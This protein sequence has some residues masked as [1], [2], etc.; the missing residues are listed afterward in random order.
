MNT[1]PPGR[2]GRLRPAKFLG[3]SITFP[4]LSLKAAVY[5]VCLG[6]L[7][8]TLGI[9]AYLLSAMHSEELIVLQ[10][11]ARTRALLA[12]SFVDDQM[13]ALLRTLKALPAEDVTQNTESRIRA[14]LDRKGIVL[15]TRSEK[16]DVLS[17]VGGLDSGPDY[18]RW[19]RPIRRG[20]RYI[21]SS[22]SNHGV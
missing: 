17:P 16:L 5:L 3:Q 10:A 22:A 4:R 18:A 7:I 9:A 15:F 14:E 12:A 20:G 11:D 21:E 6:I 13:D 19:R 2:E 8:P 1:D